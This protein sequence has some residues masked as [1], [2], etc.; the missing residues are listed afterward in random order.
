MP[1]EFQQKILKQIANRNEISLILPMGAG[2]TRITLLWSTTK[3]P[4]YRLVLCPSAAIPVWQREIHKWLGE[5]E[6]IYAAVDMS[7]HQKLGIIRTVNQSNRG[8]VL[9]P[10]QSFRSLA[11]YFANV[12]PPAVCILDESHFIQNPRALVTRGVHTHLTYARCKAILSGTPIGNSYLNV[13]AQWYFLDRGKRLGRSFYQFRYNNF[14]PDSMGWKWELKRRSYKVINDAMRDTGPIMQE[15]EMDLP[16]KTYSEIYVEPTAWQ[17]KA[18]RSLK[19]EFAV[20][21]SDGRPISVTK[22]VTTQLIRMRQV[23]SG[24]CMMDQQFK[25][26]DGKRIP[27]GKK[28]LVR[29]TTQKYDILMELLEND[30]KDHKVVIWCSFRHEIKRVHE[31]L[32][33][34]A[35]GHVMYKGGMTNDERKRA[36]EDF[37][38]DRSIRCFVGS[39]AAGGQALTLT[40]GSRV[41]Y[42]SNTHRVR[43]RDQSEKRTH[44]IGSEHH[45]RI[46]YTDI[47]T[48]GEAD[49]AI[50]GAVVIKR[51]KNEM[52]LMHHLMKDILMPQGEQ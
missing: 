37:Q 28:H 4:G 47:L 7:R 21:F 26:V 52:L 51:W 41:V 50:H 30:F 29:G 38:K 42:I 16:P 20:Y 12:L 2:K 10:Y 34:K 18:F 25:I 43:D 22:W 35:I 48:R 11:N 8:W 36:E 46:H 5:Q 9:M 31:L 6:I 27:L 33:K 17:A 39:I 3:P 40:A 44:R 14:T 24:F 49:V 1:Y 23:C 15:D 19:D 32:V 45:S 13:W